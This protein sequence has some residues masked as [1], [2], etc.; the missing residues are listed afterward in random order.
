MSDLNI[1]PDEARLI[2]LALTL[3]AVLKATQEASAAPP[4]PRTLQ[5]LESAVVASIISV[6]LGGWIG[7]IIID[8]Y[9]QRSKE[10]EQSIIDHK[11]LEAAKQAAT[12]EALDVLGDVE[13]HSAALVS[14]TQP[15]MQPENVART[16]RPA[17]QKLRDDLATSARVFQSTWRKRQLL[18]GLKLRLYCPQLATAWQSATDASNVLLGAADGAYENYI[19]D[20]RG[21][22]DLDLGRQQLAFES[23]LQA[24]AGALTAASPSGEPSASSSLVPRLLE[25]WKKRRQILPLRLIEI[26]PRNVRQPSNPTLAIATLVIRARSGLEPLTKIE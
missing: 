25:R 26:K 23:A 19:N 6:V 17:L 20:P 21:A 13:Y 3:N 12:I 15:Y 24:F 5:F 22:V 2:N 9:Q 7:N 16:D 18:A 8:H 11:Q 14:L 1:P 10:H 4:K